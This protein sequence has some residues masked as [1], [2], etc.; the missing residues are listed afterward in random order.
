MIYF[1]LYRALCCSVD[2]LYEVQ[3][4]CRETSSDTTVVACLDLI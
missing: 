3:E 2:W 1:V 4:G